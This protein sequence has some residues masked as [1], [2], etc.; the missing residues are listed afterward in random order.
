MTS[1]ESFP[2][3]PQVLSN[4]S[5]M[6][7]SQPTE[8][9]AQIMPIA[10]EGQDVSGLSR[11]GTGKTAAFLIPTIQRL[12]QLPS[13][14]IALCLAPTRELALQI[15][16]EAQK[17]SKDLGIR[18]VSVVGGMSSE[19]QIA[20]LRDGARLITGTPGRVIDLFKEKALN[21][22][23]VEI[24]VFDEADR[25]FDMGFID[26][27]HYVLRKVNPKRQILLFSAT[28]NF[29]V[30]NMVYEYNANPQEVNISRDVL[31][32]EKIKQ[33]LY[34]VGD[35]EKAPALLGVCRKY[36]IGRAHV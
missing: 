12:L 1:F 8:I 19:D 27:M 25:M 29:S 32:A 23:R 35:N 30:L 7:F 33:V 22:G 34:H 20:A 4:L 31:T 11:T 9:Q 17:I 16:H 24:L 13:D 15:E 28:M 18:T 21:L 26:D 14:R 36:E 10:L 6:G 2:L 3:D 5:A